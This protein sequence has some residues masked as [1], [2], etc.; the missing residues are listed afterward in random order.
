MKPKPTMAPDILGQF[1]NVLGSCGLPIEAVTAGGWHPIK[2]SVSKS[3][4]IRALVYS[5]FA[6]YSTNIY[7]MVSLL[8]SLDTTHEKKVSSS[9]TA[10]LTD[11]RS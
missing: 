8:V 5:E 11:I 3:P 1:A 2:L 9:Q 7:T 4:D 6:I 10:C